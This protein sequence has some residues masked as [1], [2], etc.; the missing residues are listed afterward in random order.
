MLNQAATLDRVVP[1]L[2]RAEQ[3]IDAELRRE[4]VTRGPGLR[5]DSSLDR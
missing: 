5:A 2:A 4:A 3:W 1:A